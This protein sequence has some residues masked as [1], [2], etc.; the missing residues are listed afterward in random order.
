LLLVSVFTALTV[1]LTNDFK[2]YLRT[3]CSNIFCIL[4]GD[5]LMRRAEGLMRFSKMFAG[6][7]EN[8]AKKDL[9]AE[10]ISRIPFLKGK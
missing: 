9:E 10:V 4:K 5:V 3:C 7:E 2:D 8:R 1:N 6:S